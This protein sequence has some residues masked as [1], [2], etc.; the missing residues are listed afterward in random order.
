MMI[1]RHG[2]AVLED[3]LHGGSNHW[4]KRASS[5]PDSLIP[6]N[7]YWYLGGSTDL[8][9]FALQSVPT[10]GAMTAFYIDPELRFTDL[11]LFGLQPFVFR[12][13][14]KFHVGSEFSVRIF[15]GGAE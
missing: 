6:A 3:A 9:G 2:H 10:Y 8:R 15:G 12:I 1:V 14:D 5:G 7:F 11:P 4:R 13:V